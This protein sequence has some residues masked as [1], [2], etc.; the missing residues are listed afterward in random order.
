MVGSFQKSQNCVRTTTTK[1]AQQFTCQSSLM[2]TR[3]PWT[4]IHQLTTVPRT[5]V[6]RSPEMKLNNRTLLASTQ[7]RPV[8]IL[9]KGRHDDTGRAVAESS[10]GMLDEQY[11]LRT[12]P[13]RV[14][15]ST[16][17]PGELRGC[18][19]EHGFHW[20]RRDTEP[21]K[22]QGQLKGVDQEACLQLISESGQRPESQVAA[23]GLMSRQKVDSEEQVTESFN[24]PEGFSIA[25]YWTLNRPSRFLARCVWPSKG[26]SMK[27]A[28]IEITS[29]DCNTKTWT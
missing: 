28:R 7:K 14:R 8:K 10:L 4:T 24:I 25:W 9:D 27:D 26:I 5:M 15:C 22:V 13:G 20:G 29:Q 18:R 19:H 23:L 16:C 3:D 11:D 6:G 17:R 12:Q 1:D 21:L 2:R